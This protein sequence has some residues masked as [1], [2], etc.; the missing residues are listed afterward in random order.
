M[1]VESGILTINGGSSSIKFA[2]FSPS[3]V[4]QR[5][6]HG[7]IERIGQSDTRLVIQSDGSHRE[8]RPISAGNY[9]H[10]AEGLVA[11]LHE[12]VGKAA[13]I[14]VGHRVVHGGVHVVDHQIVTPELIAELRQ[15]QPLDLAHLPREI[16][17]IETFR[18]AFPSVLQVAC[19]DTAF[20][21]DMPPVASLLPIPRHYHAAGI[22]RFGFHGLSFTYLMSRLTLEAGTEAANGRVI[23]AHLGSGAS[24]AA[25]RGGKCLDTTMGFTPTGGLVMGT[26]PGDI[27]PGLLVYLM[28]VEK[29]S[30]DEMDEFISRK[31]G[32]L[33]ISET[34]YDMRDLLKYRTQDER[35]SDA[36]EIFCYQAKKFLAALSA[37]LGGLDTLVFSGGIGENS[38]DVRS[39]I[40]SD[41]SYMGLAVDGSRNSTNAAVIS[42]DDSRVT[43]RVIATDE[44]QVIAQAVQKFLKRPINPP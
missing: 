38:S 7:Q 29:L 27:D 16:A 22:R 43:I 23:L 9:R 12:R 15:T 5:T 30:P 37:I 4:P 1:G 33:G 41:L 14:G 20:H 10:A 8:E 25:V 31:C 36:V 6:L 19:F 3:P 39:M 26:R 42:R 44:E 34:S 18:E 35:A 13:I 2:L 24:M 32:L 17:L 11:F 21:R 40:C 28:R